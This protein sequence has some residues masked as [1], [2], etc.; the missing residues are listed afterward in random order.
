MS[1]HYE[2]VLYLQAKVNQNYNVRWNRKQE[3]YIDQCI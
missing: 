3:S 1:T 2:N